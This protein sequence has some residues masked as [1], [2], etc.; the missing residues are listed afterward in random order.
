MLRIQQIL[1]ND[2]SFENILNDIYEYELSNINKNQINI[3][4]DTSK[5]IIV[6]NREIV[7]Y[8]TNNDIIN[9]T[10]INDTIVNDIRML[11]IEKIYAFISNNQYDENKII[12]LYE[13][14][15][16]DYIKI[17]I[18]SSNYKLLWIFKKLNMQANKF[19]P[20]EY[21]ANKLIDIISC[22]DTINNIVTIKY[23]T[24]IDDKTQMTTYLIDKLHHD[25]HVALCH[26]L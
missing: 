18:D 24:D 15:D 8:L 21:I 19:I 7:D 9:N 13:C 4:F 5:Q 1:D 20:T 12:E 2:I 16:I 14:L 17:I 10:H 25:M 23:N 22:N 26:C 11:Y 6:I 3:T